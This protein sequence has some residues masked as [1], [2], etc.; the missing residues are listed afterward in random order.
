[1]RYV[2]NKKWDCFC[3]KPDHVLLGLLNGFAR[4]MYER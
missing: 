4:E 3:D 1:M 2:P